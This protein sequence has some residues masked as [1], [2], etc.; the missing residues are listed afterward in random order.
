MK[1][2]S[3]LYFNSLAAAVLLAQPAFADNNPGH[4]LAQKF[5]VGEKTALQPAKQKPKK[6]A[7]TKPSPRAP[8]PGQDYEREL[9]EAA[10]AEA[11][12]RQAQEPQTANPPSPAAA[13]AQSLPSAM[14]TA[15]QAPQPPGKKSMPQVQ[16]KVQAHVPAPAAA[17]GHASRGTPAT[18]LVVLHQTGSGEIPKSFDPILCLGEVCYVSSGSESDA[19]LVSRQDAL[20][21]KSTMAAGAGACA[22][23]P[24]CAFRGVNLPEGASAQIVDLG[25]VRQE[26][27]ELI[28]AKIDPTCTVE[29]GILT[30]DKPIASLDYRIWI[31]PE[32][33]AAKAGP[34]KIEAA[35]D[36]ELPEENVTLETDK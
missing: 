31:M 33:V 8:A 13:P 2:D 15:T 30:C 25:L 34:E 16:I 12:Q 5:A 18:I 36:A 24:A 23:T 4:A 28:A 6:I 17:P 21:A 35:L 22:G 32:T 3:A 20:S 26:Q 19:R 14:P 29:D 7:E 9:L 10:K 27:R 11:A 1:R